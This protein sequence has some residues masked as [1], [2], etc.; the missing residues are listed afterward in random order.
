MK[1]G[2]R[3]TKLGEVCEI[4]MGQ[5][6][7]GESY[8]TTGEGVP[9]I[10]GP[11]EFSKGSFGHT[12]KSKFTTQ[13]TKFCKTGDLIL[14]VRGSTTG[15]MNIAGFDACIGRGVAAIRAKQF[16][17]WI[18]HFISSKRDEIHGKGTGAT[19]P[20]VS[21]AMVADFEICMPPIPE[22]QRIVTLLDEAFDGIATAK[23]NAEKNLQNARAI[24]E[25]HLQSVF[26]QRGDGWAE[27]RL[28]D[29]CAITSTLVDPRKPEFLDLTH[30]G[31]GNIESKTGAFVELKTAR[32]EGLISGKFLFDESMVLY[33][34][35]R[36]YLMKVARP[37]FNGLCSADMYPLAPIPSEA[38]KNYLFHLLL[39]KQ[40]T[41]YAIEGSARAGM[42]KV[43]REHLFEFRVSMPL[44]EKQREIAAKFDDLQRETE[45]LE[46]IFQQKLTALEELK[47][48][49]LHR[50]FNGEL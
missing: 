25:S 37:N 6:P 35:I 38:D 5:S 12:V 22:Q 48:S 21:G 32:E 3:V 19:F 14:C 46:A 44:V 17:P 42:P 29:V 43:N 8:N 16:Q 2:W 4:I 13:P 18:N 23:A 31:A 34:K 9:L 11:V 30:V 26:V 7:D 40:F 15:K 41:D 39:S 33:S 50:A 47:M 36:P 28:A 20:N 24:F 49:L 45:R 10:N 1:A 27:K